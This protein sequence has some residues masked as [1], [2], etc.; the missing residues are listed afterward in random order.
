MN[1]TRPD[2]YCGLE[3]LI[4][5]GRMV[6][7]KP[8]K[9]NPRSKGYACRKGLN[10]LY[11]Q[12]P[13]DRLTEPL[14][15][16]GEKFEPISWEQAIAEIAEKLQD[17]VDNHGPRCL[18][19]MGGGAQGGHMEAAFGLGLLRALGSQYYYSSAGQEFSGSWWVFGRLLGK[20]YNLAVPDEHAA[21]MLVGWGWNGMQSHQMPRAPIVL[22]EFSKNPDKLLVVVDPRKS[23]TAAIAD[24]HLAVRPGT[25]AL[26]ARAMVALILDK[27]W[28][29][30]AYLDTHV[31]GW[32]R[33]RP[34]FEGFDVRAAL[35]VCG[36][37]YDTKN[38]HRDPL[39][40]PLHRF[41]PCRVE[42]KS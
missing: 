15:R 1:G 17:L 6:K 23:E 8:D 42:A 2:A 37:D 10:V 40:T 26:L 12:Y 21:A 9:A 5:A 35:D 30:Q 31:E 14:K 13:A 20:Q 36:L 3:I 22:K 28:Q 19:Y 29:N 39:G 11:H 18:A 25:D 7:V 41:V 32:D 27:G 16:V 34:W 4:E 38:T 33:S 24:H